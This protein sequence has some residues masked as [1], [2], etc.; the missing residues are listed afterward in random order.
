MPYRFRT[1]NNNPGGS[2]EKAEPTLQSTAH[3]K[4]ITVVRDDVDASVLKLQLEENGPVEYVAF[5]PRK[6]KLKIDNET[7][8]Q[9]YR[10]WKE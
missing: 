9:P 8:R 10:Y 3:S 4:G 2:Q 6:R 5:N 1:H 7:V